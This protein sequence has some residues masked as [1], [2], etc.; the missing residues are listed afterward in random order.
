[1]RRLLLLPIVLILGC[2]EPP[3]KLVPATG[4]VLAKGEPLT[5]GSIYFHPDAANAWA[6]DAPSSLLQLDGS[7]EMATFP[8]GPGVTPGKY[9]VTL[10]P[11]L[12]ARARR[13]DLADKAKTPWEVTVPDAGLSGHVFEVK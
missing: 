8:F 4:R 1:M 13:P 2:G 11:A 5:A 3:P 9:R 10:A 7:F 12:A 6:K